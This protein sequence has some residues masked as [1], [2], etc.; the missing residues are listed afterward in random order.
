MVEQVEK[1]VEELKN[2]R[3]VLAKMLAQRKE[4]LE[5]SNRD[6][7]LMGKI[8]DLEAKHNKIVGDK[9]E[10]ATMQE[11]WDV[12][13]ERKRLQYELQLRQ[14]NDNISR[15]E[16]SVSQTESELKEYDEKIGDQ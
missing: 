5:F 2:N 6:K 10:F 3:K 1:T 7:E 15:L 9:L 4:D 11:Y 12:V 14:I 16:E 13:L 8:H